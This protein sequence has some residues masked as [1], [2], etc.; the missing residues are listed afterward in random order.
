MS[1]NFVHFITQKW[2]FSLTALD[3]IKIKLNSSRIRYIY[4]QDIQRLFV[5]GRWLLEKKCTKFLIKAKKPSDKC[6][7]GRKEERFQNN[8]LL[9]DIDRRRLHQE[10]TTANT[11]HL[12]FKKLMARFRMAKVS[13]CQAQSGHF[14]YVVAYLITRF[15]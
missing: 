11:F 9:I 7:L 15:I 10:K 6:T 12:T 14:S 2:H 8:P 13:N 3:Q 4:I 1:S 5:N